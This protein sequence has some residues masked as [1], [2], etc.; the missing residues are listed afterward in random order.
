LISSW[1][2]CG[3]YEASTRIGGKIGRLVGAKQNEVIACDSTSVNLFKLIMA[4]LALHPDRT[5]IVTDT[6]N[7][8]SDI[9]V[10]QVRT[11]FVSCS[12]LRDSHAVSRCWCRA[13]IK[14]L[15]F[16]TFRRPQSPIFGGL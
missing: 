14:K 13:Q 3:W 6:L 9:Y 1:G 2:S 8:P 12:E 15:R 5:K 16:Y 4:A 10:I 7:F 11:A